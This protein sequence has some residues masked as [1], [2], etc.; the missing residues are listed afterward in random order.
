RGGGGGGG[1]PPRRA[2]PPPPPPP[3]PTRLSVNQGV[4]EHAF[5]MRQCKRSSAN[6]SDTLYPSA[7]PTGT[8]PGV[9]SEHGLLIAR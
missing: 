5:F 8:R 2:P 4:R 6:A 3:T 7:R 9:A 1:P